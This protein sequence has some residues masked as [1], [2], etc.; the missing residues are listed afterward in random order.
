MSKLGLLKAAVSLAASSGVGAVVGNLVRHTTPQGLTRAQKVLVGI[1][2]F[3]LS[4]IVGDMAGKQA[5][6][7][8]DAAAEML[9]GLAG[10]GD[11]EGEE[12]H[13]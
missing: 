7:N 2:G 8:I 4:T 10:G 5:E 1:G 6:R 13:G 3:A 11:M 12:E 9:G